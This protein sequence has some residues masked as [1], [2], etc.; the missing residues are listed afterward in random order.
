MSIEEEC[1]KAR[2]RADRNYKADP[3]KYE[4]WALRL[5]RLVAAAVI[6]IFVLRPLLSAIKRLFS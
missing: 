4:L 5:W 6:F 3:L 2:E 1:R